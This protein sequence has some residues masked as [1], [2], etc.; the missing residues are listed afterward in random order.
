MSFVFGP[1]YGKGY[2][3]PVFDIL[4]RNGGCEGVDKAGAPG[5]DLEDHHTI[6]PHII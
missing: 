6:R 2:S 4:Y 3:Q 1:G 5:G